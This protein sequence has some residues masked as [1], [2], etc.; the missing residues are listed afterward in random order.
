MQALWSSTIS[1]L[2]HTSLLSLLCIH[3]VM[4]DASSY[5][6][7]F[8]NGGVYSDDKCSIEKDSLNHAM[9]LVGYVDYA[10]SDTS[11]WILKNR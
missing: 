3:S 9:L 2:L 7:L 10:E 5:N 6:F 11:Y 8:Y 1:F 4:M